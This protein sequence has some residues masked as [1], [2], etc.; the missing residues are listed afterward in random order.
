MLQLINSLNRFEKLFLIFATIV[1][2]IGF[3]FS[4]TQPDFFRYSYVI[5]DG[6]LESFTAFMLALTG[7][8]CLSKTFRFR[9]KKSLW[10]LFC[11]SCLGIIFLFGAGEEISW[12]QRIFDIESSGFFTEHN[13]QKEMNLHNLTISTSSGKKLKINKLIFGTLLGIILGIYMLI[14][15]VLYKKTRFMSDLINKSA[16]P[17]AKWA[18]TLFYLFTFIFIN[19]STHSKKGELLEFSGSIV[20][21]L[22]IMFPSNKKELYE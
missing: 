6:L 13:A 21:F 22:I 15:P 1:N 20:F 9:K 17:L 2:V 11:L 8:Y 14:L 12:G 10:F 16:V 4:M 19:F 18:H 7:F 5:E 3:Y